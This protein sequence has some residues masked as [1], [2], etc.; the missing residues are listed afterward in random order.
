MVAPTKTKEEAIS[1]CKRT[2]ADLHEQYVV[3][4]V[5]SVGSNAY[6]H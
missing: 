2:L 4:P 6:K 1:K 5:D 3:V